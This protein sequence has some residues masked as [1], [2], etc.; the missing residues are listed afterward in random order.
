VSH[1]AT[2]GSFS[3][4]ARTCVFVN[5]AA[6]AGGASGVWMSRPFPSYT[7]AVTGD[8]VARAGGTTATAQTTTRARRRT[9]AIRLSLLGSSERPQLVADEV[10]RRHDYDRDRLPDELSR[11]ERDEDVKNEQVRA[12]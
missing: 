3:T 8:V 12:E 10:Q 1:A 6:F 2:F 9:T 11:T 5:C 4:S 7:G